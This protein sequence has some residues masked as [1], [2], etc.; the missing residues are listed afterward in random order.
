MRDP[1][2]NVLR[3]LHILRAP[4]GGLFRHVRDLAQ[5]Q[6]RAGHEVGII[7]DVTTGDAAAEDELTRLTPSCTLGIQRIAMSRTLNFS[8]LSAFFAIRRQVEILAPHVLHGHGAKG[9]AYARM[10]PRAPGRVALYTPHGGAL[11]Y[12]W[13]QPSGAFFL[14]VE[15]LL[16]PRSDGLLFESQ[17]SAQAYARKIGVPSC[18][19]LVVP[20]GLGEN[21]FAPL[22][23]EEPIY[24]AVFV[25]ELRKLKGVATLI[26]AAARLAAERPFRLGI[27]GAGPDEAVFRAQ[28]VEKGIT[29]QVDFLGHRP[30]RTV[31]AQG[32]MIVVPSLAESFPYIVLE[33]VACG[34]LVI[35]TRTGGIPEI[36]GPH[37]DALVPP[38]DVSA[39]AEAIRHG[40]DN[41]AMAKA[42]CVALQNRAR[43]LF[44]VRRMAR[45]VNCFYG[46]RVHSRFGAAVEQRRRVKVP[47]TNPV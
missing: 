3:I 18:P 29:R 32:R 19:T 9:G 17:F 39:L 36:F 46:E 28:V 40:L 35:A 38:G 5:E 14:S 4:V 34:R 13:T 8:D 15:R 31:F 33:A 45:D 7:C 6:S 11:H 12:K 42:R 22:S 10:M 37:S 44:S 24:D 16:R 25:G 21:D 2:L 41:P 26:E 30:A 20:N 47:E 43:D 27:A 23:E 1:S